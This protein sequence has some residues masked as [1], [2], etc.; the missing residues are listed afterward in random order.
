[1]PYWRVICGGVLDFIEVFEPIGATQLSPLCLARGTPVAIALGES[2][3][4]TAA[5]LC[6][7]D[8]Q[9]PSRYS[10]F[11]AV[12]IAG[13]GV[14]YNSGLFGPTD[15]NDHSVIVTAA[16]TGSLGLSNGALTVAET[17]LGSEIPVIPPNGPKKI[18]TG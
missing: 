16:S 13:F 10:I 14:T 8:M 7:N 5:A 6:F 11:G 18:S 4:A 3:R 9:K 15:G 1:M 17:I 12:A 2:L